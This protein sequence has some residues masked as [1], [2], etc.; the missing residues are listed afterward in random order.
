MQPAN[1]LIEVSDAASQ[2]I[3]L[4][5]TL[6]EGAVVRMLSKDCYFFRAFQNWDAS[7]QLIA[8]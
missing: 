7:N 2:P 6:P 4:M 1:H 3:R 5:L 8:L